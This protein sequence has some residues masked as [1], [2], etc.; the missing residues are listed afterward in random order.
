MSL[1]KD[2]IETIEELLVCVNNSEPNVEEYKKQLLLFSERIPQELLVLLL[3]SLKSVNKKNLVRAY[4][5]ICDSEKHINKNELGESIYYIK[6]DVI[7]IFSSFSD[8]EIETNYSLNE[9]RKMY[10]A[11]YNKK[12]ASKKTKIEIIN[13][14]RNHIYRIE[15]AKTFCI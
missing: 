6:N 14:I 2:G 7:D 4:N 3:K 15:R 13:T 12:P 1:N 5:A 11:I 10:E 9:L 8:E